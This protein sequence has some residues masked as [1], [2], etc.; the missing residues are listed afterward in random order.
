MLLLGGALLDDRLRGV[1]PA[2]DPALGRRRIDAIDRR[3]AIADWTIVARRDPRACWCRS[4]RL[5]PARSARPRCCILYP[6]LPVARIAG[7]DIAHAVPLTLIAGIGHWLM[8]SVDFA[9]MV[10]LLVGSIPGIIV[11]SLLGSR[12]VGQA[13]SPMLAATLLIVVGTACSRG[14][15]R[16]LGWLN[17]SSCIIAPQLIGIID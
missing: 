7:S 8:G 14:P 2:V 3:R 13:A 1:L 5:A 16:R 10:A 15:E 11:G 12:V 17:R 4:P 9:L 6:K